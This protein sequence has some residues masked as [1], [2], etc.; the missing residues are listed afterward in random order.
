MHLLDLSTELIKVNL[1]FGVVFVHDELRG[2]VR[3]QGLAL[4]PAVSVQAGN[5]MTIALGP[6]HLLITFIMVP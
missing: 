5:L 4:L 3:R 2:V 6:S 1:L